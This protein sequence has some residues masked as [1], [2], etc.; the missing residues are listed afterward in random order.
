MA[1]GIQGDRVPP[2]G[3]QGSGRARP[4]MAGLPATVKKENRGS[5]WISPCVGS[6]SQPIGSLEANFVT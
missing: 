1:T 3:G 6:Q 5:L 2:S 4:G